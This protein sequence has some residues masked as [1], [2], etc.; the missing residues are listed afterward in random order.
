MGSEL[1][2]LIENCLKLAP[3]LHEVQYIQGLPVICNLGLIWVIQL[4]SVCTGRSG[5]ST[6][7]KDFHKT[8]Y[9]CVCVCEGVWAFNVNFFK[10]GLSSADK[11][12]ILGIGDPDS[13][14][15]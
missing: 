3:A 4:L 15:R 7:Q 14:H 6:D 1:R 9:V 2:N 8:L 11:S 5:T 10:A 12:E 13:T